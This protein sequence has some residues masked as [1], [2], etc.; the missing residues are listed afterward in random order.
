MA[1]AGRVA[2]FKRLLAA[3]GMHADFGGM[4]IELWYHGVCHL[5][6]HEADL[7]KAIMFLSGWNAHREFTRPNR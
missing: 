7:E 2:T 1:D 5:Q 4:S 3:S 6:V